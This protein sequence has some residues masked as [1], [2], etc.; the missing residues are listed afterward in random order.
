[1]TLR[2][3]F[4]KH[5][6]ESGQTIIEILIATGVIALVMTAVASG[7]TLSVKNTSQA[8]YR[9]LGTKQAQ[10]AMEMYR[11]ER[12]RL[13]WE[14]FHAVLG[15]GQYCLGESLPSTSQEFINLPTGVCEASDGY[16]LGGTTYQRESEVSLGAVD[17]P[18]E[19]T[20]EVSWDDGGTIRSTSVTQLL[21]DF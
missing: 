15:N 21:R 5:A 2:L 16:D 6:S 8:K 9:A 19:I 1:M 17:A 18:I 11:R 14:S 13:G 12:S 3:S 4:A 10:E 7:L 20:I